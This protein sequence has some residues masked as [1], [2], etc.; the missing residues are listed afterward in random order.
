M[1]KKILF[2]AILYVGVFITF[3]E[4]SAKLFKVIK[5]LEYSIY[6]EPYASIVIKRLDHS[7]RSVTI[8]INAKDQEIIFADKKRNVYCKTIHLTLGKNKVTLTGINNK[9]KT[10]RSVLNLFFRSELD[11]GTLMAP[12]GYTKNFFHTDRNEKL[13]KACHHM[14]KDT[15]FK[16]TKKIKPSKINMRSFSVMRNPEKSNCFTCHKAMTRGKYGHAPAVNFACTECHNGKSGKNNSNNFGRSKYLTQ[17]PTQD[18]CFSCHKGIKKDIVSAYSTHATL[19]KGQCTKCHDPHSSDHL[20]HL[21]KSIVKLCATCHPEKIEGKHILGSFVFG[22]NRGRHPVQGAKDP[23]R[24]GRKLVC[25]SCHNPH[26]SQGVFLLRTKG[27]IPY[28][29]C[30]R[31]H[32]K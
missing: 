5:P 9:G 3:S 17:D 11:R 15:K 20:F 30:Q 12:E 21:R 29:V 31:C 7:L 10:T 4:A 18:M 8:N 32:K 16:F 25:T 23:A 22:R 28:S 27:K 14:K 2:S 26:G 24:K 19:A 1:L 13:C 6:H